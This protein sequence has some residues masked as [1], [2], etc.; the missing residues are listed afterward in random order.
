MVVP[1]FVGREKSIAALE[2]ASK[3]N[4]ELFL[5]TQKDA[6][7]LNPDDEDIYEIGTVVNIIQMLR[8]PDNTIKV[9]IEG[10]RRARIS[11]FLNEKEGYFAEVEECEDVVLDK[12]QIEASIRS[13]KNI[14]EKYV[15]LNK[16]IPPE[17]LMSI[18][19]INDPSRLAD[20]VVA[21]LSMKIT[22]K[23][24]ILEALNLEERLSILL[25]KMQGEIEIIN[26]E[27]KIR[28]RV[29]TQMERS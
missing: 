19:A 27:K 26:V 15:K 8:L 24:E 13:L 7:I 17:L 3:N 29:K 20:I 21:H 10:K 6:S 18:S 14:F 22:E 23:Q 4:N 28:S 9:L 12:V 5:V 25:K 16:R 1:L 11:E 2:E